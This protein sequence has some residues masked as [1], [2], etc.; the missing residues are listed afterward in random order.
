[1]KRNTLNWKKIKEYRRLMGCA[2]TGLTAVLLL[3]LAVSSTSAAVPTPLVT[4]PIPVAETPINPLHDYPQLA[5]A[6]FYDLSRRGYVELEFFFQGTATS[7]STPAM[8]NG[9]VLST[10]HP[11]KSRI[12][13]R[14]PLDRSKFNGIVIVEWLN[15]TPGSG[16]D[17]HWMASHDYVTREGYAYVTVHA[18]R[19]G[20]HATPY[21]LIA[22]SPVRYG[23]LDVTDGGTITDD[24]LCYDIFSQAGMAILDHHRAG[25]D[26]LGG[27]RPKL[28]IA[29][30]LSQSASRLTLYYNSIQPLHKVYDGF[31]LHVGG[32]PFRTDVGTKLMRVNTERE[33]VGGQATLRQADSGVFR[34]WEIAGASHVDFQEVIYRMPIAA[35][36][37]LAPPNVACDNQALSHVSNK[38]VLNA[39][40][41]HI[42]KWIKHNSPP[43][44]A[45]P[46][47]VT[48]LSP[49]VIP[50]DAYGLVFG[51]I[52]LA[53]VD[54][55][56]ATNTGANTGPGFC[57]LY[58]S[59][60][61]FDRATLESLYP[62]HRSYVEKVRE[63]THRNL[64]DGFVVEDDA[65]EIIRNAEVSLIGTDYPLPLP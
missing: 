4:G 24:S 22:W 42:V 23:T 43:P 64:R 26:M 25:V 6:P 17:F 53:E 48:S 30:G 59:H 61:G 12:I 10:G 9:V 62:T 31:V 29:V 54:A 55:P 50:R 52:R 39:A 45:E 60:Q 16:Q 3:M 65:E 63:V 8:A 2:V 33:I 20:I 14:R 51:G 13:V 5:S 56:T 7:Y 47:T 27:L 46:I 35:R 44:I 41:D 34:G 49:L 18:Q 1:M 36:D 38:Y 21:G 40:Y 19:V 15:V 32:G 58:G 57:G 28:V 37:Q 11:Y